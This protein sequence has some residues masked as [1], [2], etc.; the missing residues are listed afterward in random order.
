[1][2]RS[3]HVN[4]VRQ[5]WVLFPVLLGRHSHYNGLASQALGP[6]TDLVGN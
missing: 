4:G 1:L 2:P 6:A 3:S 5:R